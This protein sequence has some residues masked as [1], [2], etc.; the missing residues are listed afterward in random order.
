[1]GLAT[2]GLKTSAIPS[3]RASIKASC[4]DARPSA[5]RMNESIDI[6][7]TAMVPVAGSD[8]LMVKPMAPNGAA[9]TT[10]PMYV[11]W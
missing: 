8:R 6:C 5:G 10:S 2:G 11:F 3:A 1:M 9:L 4:G 7:A